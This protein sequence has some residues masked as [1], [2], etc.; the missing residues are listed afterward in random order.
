MTTRAEYHNATAQHFLAQAHDYL[1]ADDLLQASEKGWGAAAQAVKSVA[2]TR[3]WPHNGH[4][5]LFQAI[6]RLVAETGDEDIRIAF[7]LAG[8]LHTNFYEGW[9]AR[10][11]IEAHL[12]QVAGLVEKLET[13]TA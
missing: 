10:E 1:A 13:R 8:A 9:L 2:E 5:Q 11:A 12:S 4:R 3:G 7:G 6:D